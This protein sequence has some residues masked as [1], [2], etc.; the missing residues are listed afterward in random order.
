MALRL[1]DY[2]YAPITQTQTQQPTQSRRGLANY[3]SEAGGIVGG[4]GGGALGALFGGAGAA[5]GAVAGS[6]LG[7]GL[8]QKLENKLTGKNDSALKEALYSGVGEVAG[9]GL[10]ALG[11]KLISKGATKGATTLIRKAYK[12]TASEIRKSAF[13]NAGE[14]AEFVAK[15][16][17]SLSDDAISALQ[18]QY[19]D[20]ATNS[21]VKTNANKLIQS[22]YREAKQ[23]EAKGPQKFKNFAAQIK[24]EAANIESALGKGKVDIA[25]LT[26]LRRAYDETVKNFGA[27]EMTDI[28]KFMRT[29]LKKAIDTAANSA[30]EKSNGKTLGQL[31]ELLSK[32]YS[33]KEL[34]EKGLERGANRGPLTLG[35]LGLAGV[36]GTGGPVGAVT[37][38]VVGNALGNPAVIGGGAGILGKIGAKT[39]GGLGRVGGNITGSIG[40]GIF[41]GAQ[42][43]STPTNTPQNELLSPTMPQNELLSQTGITEPTKPQYDISVFRNAAVKDM[44]ETGGKN[45]DKITKLAEFLGVGQEAKKKAQT[46][47]QAQTGGYAARLQSANKIFDE[48]E[49]QVSGQLTSKLS[50]SRNL[51]DRLKSETVK[52]QEQAEQNFINAVLRRESGAAIAPSEYVNAAKQY[53]PQPGDTKA[54]LEQK[55]L[56]RLLVQQNLML[57][58]QG[59]PTY[60]PDTVGQLLEQYSR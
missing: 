22:L 32:Q 26:A 43:L 11:A 1:Q 4:I 23:L 47:T 49:S 18:S 16:N 10:G 24:A 15:N 30:G 34:I 31:G 60:T 3:V 28:G 13:K 40:Q 27:D 2:G 52:R 50:V 9:L 46:A 5:P 17:A 56:N 59:E 53:F 51:P 55:R 20:I 12:P 14:F 48:L 37:G 44:Q 19:D 57:E 41:Q 39:A 29:R 7:A 36:G 58:A 38:A 35:T 45:L 8:G 6:A 42:S 33:A 54:V 25:D 21:G